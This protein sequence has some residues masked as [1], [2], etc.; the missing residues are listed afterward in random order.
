MINKIRG[1]KLKTAMNLGIV[2]YT[3]A[4]IVSILIMLGVI[5]YTWVNGGRSESFDAQLELTKI[6]IIILAI[7]FIFNLVAGKLI[8]FKFK[9]VITVLCW[10]LFAYWCLSFIMQLIGTPFER[11]VISWTILIGVVANYR[12]AIEKR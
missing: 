4:I 1:M 6:N 9:K 11:F 8:P 12:L 5:P 2:F 7:G 3:V 10:F